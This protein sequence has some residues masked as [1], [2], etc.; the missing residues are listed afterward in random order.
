MQSSLTVRVATVSNGWAGWAAAPD[1]GARPASFEHALAGGR[2][3]PAPGQREQVGIRPGLQLGQIRQAWRV[4]SALARWV[5]TSRSTLP[6][7]AG[8]REAGIDV[9]PR[10]P[11]VA[12]V[13][14]VE[15]APGTGAAGDGGLGVVDP[16]RRR[17]AAEAG[18]RF[19][20]AGQPAS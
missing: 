12:P 4:G 3:A 6:L 15:F 16:H 8:A 7:W 11:G 14:G 17:Y 13:A 9:E 18:E 1:G 5:R 19:V 20:V 2:A 10:R